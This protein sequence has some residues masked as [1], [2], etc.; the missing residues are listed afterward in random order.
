M[1]DTLNKELQGSIIMLRN[2]YREFPKVV[3]R[4]LA[5]GHCVKY[6][7]YYSIAW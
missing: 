7:D 6:K 1:T 5:G 3:Q 2:E 4:R